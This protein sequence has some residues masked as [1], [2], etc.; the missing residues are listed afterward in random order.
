MKFSSGEK[1]KEII[2][3]DEKKNLEETTS[4]TMEDKET[5]SACSLGKA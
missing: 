5:G 3:L 1:E 2:F 4:L